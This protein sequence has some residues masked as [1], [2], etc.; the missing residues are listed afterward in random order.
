MEKGEKSF[1]SVLIPAPLKEPLLYSVPRPMRESLKTGTR[2]LVPL[3]RRKISGVVVEFCAE[4]SIPGVREILEPLDDRPIV[5]ASLLNLCRWMAKYY[6][7]SLG[8]VLATVLPSSLRV[9]SRKTVVLRDGDVTVQGQL[10]NEILQE[11]KG[12]RRLLVKSL[13]GKF[14]DRGLYR[15]LDHLVSAGAVEIHERLKKPRSAEAPHSSP[16]GIGSSVDG[17]KKPILTEEQKTA[18]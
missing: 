17:L 12:R 18:L 3:G 2:V 16:S 5:D 14:S 15:A 8:E 6:L 7:A 11:I 9:E 10:A 1:A 4:T 13:A